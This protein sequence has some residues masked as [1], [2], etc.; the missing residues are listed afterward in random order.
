MHE[1]AWLLLFLFSATIVVS[2]STPETV[3]CS[4]CRYKQF[5]FKPGWDID[6]EVFMSD[7]LRCMLA[8][9]LHCCSCR[10]S[11]ACSCWF[12]VH[13]EWENGEFMQGWLIVQSATSCMCCVCVRECVSACVSACVRECVRMYGCV[14]GRGEVDKWCY[15]YCAGYCV[16]IKQW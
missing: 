2:H 3:D 16:A 7:Q 11:Q 9:C 4:F 12:D 5:I 10:Q 8:V 15:K 1:P 14:R 6:I 13:R